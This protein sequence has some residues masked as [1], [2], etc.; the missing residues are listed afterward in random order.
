[1]SGFGFNQKPKGQI[2]RKI[3]D[4]YERLRTLLATNRKLTIRPSKSKWIDEL[5]KATQGGKSFEPVPIETMIRC[6]EYLE[7][8]ITKPYCPQVFSASTFIQKINQIK[9][10]ADNSYQPNDEVSKWAMTIYRAVDHFG[11]PMDVGSKLP[12]FIDK[13]LKFITSLKASIDE[14]RG[15]DKDGRAYAHLSRQIGSPVNFVEQWMKDS[16]F[17][18]INWDGWSGNLSVIE[19]RRESQRFDNWLRQ[20]LVEYGLNEQAIER[21]LSKI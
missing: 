17:S 4:V 12:S 5:V 9:K 21:I 20:Q 10:L 18:I 2:D 19:C 1:M 8:N 6:V 16:W 11:W 7:K 13:Q 15:D 3:L 14:L